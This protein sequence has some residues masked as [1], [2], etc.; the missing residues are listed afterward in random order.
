MSEDTAEGVKDRLARRFE[1][2]DERDDGQER[3]DT[4]DSDAKGSR[5]V[6]HDRRE[7]SSRNE[8]A[9]GNDRTSEKDR[10]SKKA[11]KA[12]NVKKEWKALS[13]YLPDELESDLSKTYKRLDWELEADRDVSIKKTRHYYPLVVKLGLERLEELESNEIEDRINSF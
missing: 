3:T 2:S 13:V 1:G 6:D 9:A 7:R 8:R 10:S 11:M 4:G 5:A 12:K